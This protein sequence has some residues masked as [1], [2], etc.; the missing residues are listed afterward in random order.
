[1]LAIACAVCACTSKSGHASAGFGSGAG[2]SG[3]AAQQVLA[4]N[5]Q[6]GGLRTPPPDAP[7]DVIIADSAY[8]RLGGGHA[9]SPVQVTS[10]S[11]VGDY[12]L[13]VLQIGANMSETLYEKERGAWKPVASDAYVSGG[14]GLLR[15]GISPDLAR[16][17]D[18][19]LHPV[20]Q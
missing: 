1:M 7:P 13:A 6:T 9:S 17:L 14:R 20:Q 10:V 18:A 3:S 19:S 5:G 11:V 4:G 12:G 15:F 2:S 8:N 16:Q